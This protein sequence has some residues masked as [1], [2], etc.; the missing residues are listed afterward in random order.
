[1][2][3]LLRDKP[4][5]Q[6]DAFQAQRELRARMG[7][8]LLDTFNVRN[9]ELAARL[10]RNWTQSGAQTERLFAPMLVQGAFPFRPDKRVSE[11]Q[12]PSTAERDPERPLHPR[13]VEILSAAGLSY[14]L[15]EHQVKTVREASQGKTVVL[16]AGTGSGKTEAFLIPLLDRLFWDDER[17][18][19][20]L[21]Q[22]GVRAM[23]IY[24][25]NALVNNQIERI[26]ELLRGQVTVSFAYYTGRLK[27]SRGDAERLYTSLGREVPPA[28]QIIDR[29]SLRGLGKANKSR[30]GPPHI[31][32]T[33]FSM[34]EYM[35]I[36]PQDHSIFQHLRF[37]GRP[38]LRAIV[39]D[40]AH[41]YGGAQAAEIHMLLRRAALRFGTRLEDI[42][43]YATSA[44]LGSEGGDEKLRAFAAAMF[45]APEDRVASVIGHRYLPP[46]GS[47]VREDLGA[48]RPPE[49]LPAD[50]PLVPEDLQTLHF[51]GLGKPIELV[52]DA[53]LARK[54]AETCVGLG[55]ADA[56]EVD[57]LIAASEN[58][59]AVLLHG[60]LSRHPRLV[61][62]RKWLF[63][64]RDDGEQEQHETRYLHEVVRKLFP[65][66][67]ENPSEAAQR[68][69]YA[70]LQLGAL[71]RLEAGQ[72]P[73]IP[74][75]MHLFM[76]TPA[77]VWVDPRP[78]AES[79]PTWPW[80][81]LTSQPRADF[82]EDE[83]WLRLYLCG[84]CSGPVLQA[85]KRSDEL[86]ESP[87]AAS[88]RPGHGMV[89]V[90][91]DA[92]S[93]S[94]LPESWGGQA[95]R[96][97][98]ID[99]GDDAGRAPGSLRL[100]CCP[101]CESKNVELE[102]LQ[103]PSRSALPALVDAIY[104]SLGEV[105][106]AAGEPPLPGGGRR[107]LAF[108]DSRQGAARVAA[109]VERT[110]DTGVNR[111]LL[112]KILSQDDEPVSYQDLHEA[113][114][115]HPLLAQRA[116]ASAIDD[117]EDPSEFLENLATVSIYEELSTPPTRGNTLEALGLVEVCYPRLRQV[118]VPEDLRGVLSP[119]VWHDLLAT[120]LD[121]A[122]RRGAVS[123]RSLGLDDKSWS[124][125]ELLPYPRDGRVLTFSG[126][127]HEIEIIDD[128]DKKRNEERIALLPVAHPER[129]RMRD[130]AARLCERRELGLDE[131]HLLR[132]VWEALEK[133]AA[134]TKCK[135]LKLVSAGDALGVQ[136]DLRKLAFRGHTDGPRFIDPVTGRVYFR[137]VMGVSPELHSRHELRE[138]TEEDRERWQRRHAVRRV[139]EHQ[140]L[141]LWSVEHTAQLDVD[142]LEEQERAFKRGKRNFMS[143]STTM[144][145]GVDLG[146]LTL[147][148]L[149]NVPPGP[150]NYWQRAGRAGR[151]ADGSSMVL[152][153]AQ[154][155]PHDQRVFSDPRAFLE[156]TM[157]PPQVRLDTRALLLRHVN[158]Y[159]LAE[160][161][162]A[163]VVRKDHGNPMRAFGHVGEFLLHEVAS[164]IEKS[165]DR[166]LVDLLAVDPHETLAD[167]FL[168]WLDVVSLDEKREALV[169]ER[170]VVRTCLATESLEALVRDCQSAFA[171]ALRRARRELEVLKQQK[172]RED[173]RG[174]GK[175]DERYLGLLQHQQR[176]LEREA[177][178]SYLVRNDFLPRFGFP[179]DVVRLDTTWQ[180]SKGRD[181]VAHPDED[182][183]SL[184][185]ERGLD[186]ALA[187]Y[188]P[189]GEVIAKKRIY[190]V[191]GLDRNWLNEDTS[192]VVNRYYSECERCHYVSFGDA[193]E[194]QACEACGHPT[195]H[196]K[197][198]LERSKKEAK[199][200]RDEASSPFA[201]EGP[202]PSP[203]RRY[204]QPVGFAVKFGRRPRRVMG[205]VRRM[206]PPQVTLGP[207]SA[208]PSEVVPGILTMGFTPG[209]PLFMRSEGNLQ[210]VPRR[211]GGTM[212]M[213]GYG[214]RICKW[215]GRAE[216]ETGW[217]IK[218]PPK[219][220]RKHALLR[221]AAPCPEHHQWWAHAVLGIRQSVDAYRVRLHGDLAPPPGNL[222]D[223]E[224]FYL[225]LAVCM[226]QVGADMLQIDPRALQPAVSAYWDD[227]GSTGVEAVVY[228][229]SGSG[230]LAH[231]DD[232]PLEMMRRICELL[233]TKDLA[234]FIQ[235]DT[236]FLF[237]QGVLR[238]PLLRR[239]LVEDA[240]RRARLMH[241]SSMF[242]QEEAMP[243]RGQT[244]RM[245][246][247]LLIE[248]GAQEIALQ[249]A[250]LDETAF[251]PGQVL[252]A[253]WARAIRRDGRDRP[254]RLLIGRLPEIKGDPGQVLL[255]SRLA[256]LIEHGVEIRRSVTAAS[257]PPLEQECWSVLA[258]SPRGARV[259]GGMSARGDVL[260]A[261][262]GPAFGDTWL[263]DGIAVENKTQ[264]AAELAWA[265]FEERWE[266][267]D[268]VA[269]ESLRPRKTERKWVL[270]IKQGDRSAEATDIA[271]ILQE[272]TKLGSLKELGK[273][274]S[275]SYRDRYV[276]LSSLT[277]WMLDRLLG[278]FAYGEG[279][280]GTVHCLKPR[281]NVTPVDKSVKDILKDRSP[282]ESLDQIAAKAF[283]TWCK[284]RSEGRG[285]ALEFQYRNQH[286]IGH[287]RKLEVTFAPG[288]QVSTMLV[289]FDHG[290]DWIR[291][292]S[293]KDTRPWTQQTMAAK[294]SHIV[295]LL[296]P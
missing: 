35:L 279:A 89:A 68:A 282:V 218:E 248:D 288:S 126:G 293:G 76:R 201:E 10:R 159:L 70:L 52:Q 198:F 71:A 63:Q 181:A 200:G 28:C 195:E 88:A 133:L 67:G 268:S 90:S 109:E 287:Q 168:R 120:V 197:Q 267:G 163:V 274:S 189:G 50:G 221:G 57:A 258:R 166:D 113:L 6:F 246:T 240:G 260:Q 157:V 192:L 49:E 42:Q 29:Q 252:R 77:G 54:A 216:P 238:I 106:Q 219:E 99:G 61:A 2:S 179:V 286:A 1:M 13:T 261:W 270:E 123:R 278:L 87:L 259:I 174:E 86:D 212:R 171:L 16:S 101:H 81:R 100:S 24:P 186:L 108:S 188:A 215:C 102:N 217:N 247:Q 82:D 3:M 134:D 26:L 125:R 58:R 83:P 266:D 284:Q 114:F 32:V 91:P 141:G 19:D 124:L 107:M 55:L 194:P 117:E 273:V 253:V 69:T 46:E 154:P 202:S 119:D 225:S 95:V 206:P 289:L 280:R 250:L 138:L 56:A 145:M 169:R 173:D 31:L 115:E 242:E 214:Y 161:Y 51:D 22:P 176:V 25:L 5:Y 264:T 292:V 205:R 226:Q 290:L 262:S 167:V 75:R 105:P 18:L 111:Q 191:A 20:D 178:L 245:A 64:G 60:V 193:A 36:R 97:E 156:R 62:L 135:W 224:S 165:I 249:A 96:I 11:L 185:M 72:H 237:Q 256:E 139:C 33:N 230:L 47:A 4:R 269:S 7:D 150:A 213:A 110:H 190:R 12:S 275:L 227:D 116:E 84:T 207:G 263:K 85:W 233:E 130:F 276:G 211:A 131:E 254:V 45:S 14:Q 160:F 148:M 220:Y 53:A 65:D 184:R 251:E 196:E 21:S 296:D 164:H 175:R 79:S 142:K 182:G 48:L 265:Q 80:G 223:M 209:S 94:R 243:L 93:S 229:T 149:A 228:D 136:I 8:Y 283:Q 118:D 281:N 127:A 144:E 234:E 103:L 59:P 34:L 222:A 43:G 92:D 204:L 277:M 39:L 137:S 73:Y 128:E 17:G 203:V 187:E 122:R 210:R 37:N 172:E 147:V 170:L 285:L 291:P 121:D 244:P 27:E 23:I 177:L 183:R 140:L 235:F 231:L 132:A 255:A 257:A 40:E 112:W 295:V 129:A 15:Y 66:Q 151:R 208:R 153:L 104:P 152:V 44:T 74:T 272:R 146:G 155:R 239:H 143:S 180:L 78:G 271:T 162:R 232:S 158:A 236:Q 30:Q 241:G 38:R 9:P 294:A 199:K 41:V 98:Q